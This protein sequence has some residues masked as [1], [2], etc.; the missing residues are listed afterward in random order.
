MVEFVIAGIFFS[1]VDKTH[2]KS[3][4]FDQFSLFLSLGNYPPLPGGR[5]ASDRTVVLR[6]DFVDRSL[7]FNL[8]F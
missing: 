4:R 8:L 5:K 2:A 7:L 3:N 1:T 6:I